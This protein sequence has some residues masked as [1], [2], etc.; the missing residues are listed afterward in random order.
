MLGF[1]ILSR[2]SFARSSGSLD[3]K[4][5][6]SISVKIQ[7]KPSITSLPEY[8]LLLLMRRGIIMYIHYYDGYYNQER[9]MTKIST[10]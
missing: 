8:D 2:T 4:L 10:N 6:L 5:R 1:L 3:L 7:S 9:E